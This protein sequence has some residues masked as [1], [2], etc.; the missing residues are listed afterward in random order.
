M[1][2]DE[3]LHEYKHL[4]EIISISVGEK[5][6][7]TIHRND[8]MQAGYEALLKAERTFDDSKNC[9]RTTYFGIRIRGAMLDEVR[10]YDNASRAARKFYREREQ[11]I[12]SLTRQL[13]R[14]PT[15]QEIASAMSLNVQQY[16]KHCSENYLAEYS[17]SPHDDPS[18]RRLREQLVDENKN[19]LR[20]F[21]R[22]RELTALHLAITTLNERERSVIKRLLN[23][24]KP[25]VFCREYGV[26]ESAI[27]LIKSKAL[28]KIQQAMG[29]MGESA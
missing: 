11:T 20:D 27:S 23:N 28:K 19:I 29:I 10:R 14:E 7:W 15:P 18:S 17:L 3:L 1:T 26:S 12:T 6:S 8:L 22:Q 13:S 16:H 21:E 4:V 24:E 25:S 9:S 5:I 2:P